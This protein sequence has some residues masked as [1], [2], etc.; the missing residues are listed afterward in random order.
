MS[1]TK[2]TEAITFF[3]QM[4][5]T[6]PGDRTSLEFLV[7]AYEQTGQSEKRRDCLIKLADT[8]LHEKDYDNAQV[9]AGY[10]SAYADF[11]PARATVQRVA[12]V[13]QNEILRG[14]YHTDISGASGGSGTHAPAFVPAFQDV[15]LE[16]HA[17]SRAAS[18]A[19]MDLVWLWKEREFLPKDICMDVLHV[20]TDRPV[21]DVPTLISALALLDEQHPEL[22][23]TLMERMQR[24]SEMPVIPI[25]LFEIQ[26]A[27]AAVLAPAYVHVRGVLP[28]ALLGN[29]ALVAVL[30]P[31]NRALQE[32]TAARAARPCHFF[33]A[34]PRT[35]QQAA[36]K[37]TIAQ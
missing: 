37:I 24:E 35:W 9:I 18:A 23:D 6:M 30:N 19:E 25:E 11:P 22:T 2:L 27:A 16:V 29:D 31:L 4:L 26:P 34:H 8:L 3:E 32:E 5:Q 1:D 15:G 20:L 33:L 21:T 12:S 10:L 28:F 36:A 7:V 13:I 17:L 14:Q